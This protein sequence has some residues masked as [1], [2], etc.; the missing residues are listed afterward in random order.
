MN[1]NWY[2]LE[3]PEIATAEDAAEAF[4]GMEEGRRLWFLKT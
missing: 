1:D 4:F 2:R 3:H